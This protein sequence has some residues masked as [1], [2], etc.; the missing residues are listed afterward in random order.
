V[1]PP[2]VADSVATALTHSERYVDPTQGH[3]ALDDRSRMALALF[4]Q[5]IKPD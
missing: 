1:T 2:D 5:G 4:I 3:A